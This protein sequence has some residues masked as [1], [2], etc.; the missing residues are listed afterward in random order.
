LHFGFRLGHQLGYDKGLDDACRFGRDRQ[1][2]RV[3]EG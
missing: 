1:D 2:H 3:K